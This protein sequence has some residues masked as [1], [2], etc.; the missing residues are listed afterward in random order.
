V[1]WWGGGRVTEGQGR[2]CRTADGKAAT[3]DGGGEM[4]GGSGHDAS[5]A[6]TWGNNVGPTL[7]DNGNNH[8][9]TPTASAH[10]RKAKAAEA[11]VDDV[12]LAEPLKTADD[13]M[14]PDGE[15]ENKRIQWSSPIEFLLTCIG[16]SV[17]LGNV[18]RFPYLCYKNGGGTYYYWYFSVRP[19]PN[20]HYNHRCKKH[21]FILAVCLNVFNSFLLL[22]E[23]LSWVSYSSPGCYMYGFLWISVV[24]FPLILALQFSFAV[25]GQIIQYHPAVF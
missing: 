20:I 13:S 23:L 25:A 16:Y 18:W 10:L 19:T 4:L 2:P 6:N 8:F 12:E 5:D 15:I 24:Q 3:L 11:G 21:F 7:V 17:G 1:V 9:P 14:L 22:E